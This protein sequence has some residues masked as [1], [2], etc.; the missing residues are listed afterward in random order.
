M[1]CLQPIYQMIQTVLNYRPASSLFTNP[2]SFVLF[3]NFSRSLNSLGNLFWVLGLLTHRKIGWEP[4]KVRSLWQK[5][6][7]TALIPLAHQPQGLEGPKLIDFVGLPSLSGGAKK[8]GIQ[9][10]GRGCRES[11]FGY[12]VWEGGC[13]S[14][15]GVC[16][17]RI[18]EWQHTCSVMIPHLHFKAPQLA[19][20]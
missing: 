12:G 4:T 15:L 9:C 10:V 8:R 19:S 11:G 16:P 18:P 6:K 3:E 5:Q 13:R 20:F 14:W 7:D 2:S 1:V 17:I